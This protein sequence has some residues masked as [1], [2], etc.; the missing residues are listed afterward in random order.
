M[1]I[2]LADRDRQIKDRDRKIAAQ[3]KEIAELR[4]KLGLDGTTQ[5][6][7]PAAKSTRTRKVRSKVTA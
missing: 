5:K 4:W 7:V 3:A 1:N 6:T 2:I